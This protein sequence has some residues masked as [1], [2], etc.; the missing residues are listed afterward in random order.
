MS[1]YVSRAACRGHR[2]AQF[3]SYCG[4]QRSALIARLLKERDVARFVV[5]P[6]GYGK[7]SLVIDY[8]ETMFAWSHTIWLSAQSPCFIRDLDAG[9]IASDCFEVDAEVGLVVIDDLPSLDANRARLFSDEMDALLERGCEVMV[10]CVPSCDV[11]GGFQH[12]RIRLGARDL[13]LSDDELDE[14]RSAEE[15]MRK[16]ANLVSEAHRVPALV[17]NKDDESRQAFA[18]QVLKEELPSDLLLMVASTLVLQ[19][20]SFDDLREVTHVDKAT[21]SDLLADYPHLGFVEETDRFEAAMLDVALL[22]N[23]TKSKLDDMVLR[24]VLEDSECL[25]V[26]W[27]DILLRNGFAGRACDVMRLICPRRARASWLMEHSY[28]L[29]RQACFFPSLLLARDQREARGESKTRLS[30]FEALCL[31]ALGDETGALR[32]AKRCAFDSSAPEETKICGALII[33]H[34]GSGSLIS[35]AYEVLE[36]VAGKETEA[37]GEAESSWVQLAQAWC[38]VA[39]GPQ[40]LIALWDRFS[41]QGVSEDVL[42]VC[43]SWLFASIGAGELQSE[44]SLAASGVMLRPVERYV[45]ER[46]LSIHGDSTDYFAASAGLSLEEAHMRG[47]PYNDGPLEAEIMFVLRQVEV[48]VLAQRS[49]YDQGVRAARVKRND[50]EATRP[51]SYLSVPSSSP[52]VAQSVPILSLKMFGRFEVTIGDVPI[53]QKRFKRQNSRVLLVLLAVNQGKEVSREQLM[54]AMW[55]SATSDVGR[56]NFYTVWAQLR[57]SLSL[58]DG[59]CPYLIRH[60]YGCSLEQRYVQSDVVRLSEICRELLFGNPDV[61]RWSSLFAEIDRDF[62]SELMPSERRNHMIIQARGEYRSRLVDALVAAT[63]SIVDA[64][65]PQWGIWFAREA[66][67]HDETREDAYVA[68]MRAQIAGNQR[69]AAMMTF[70]KCRRVLNDQLGIDPS[71]EANSLYESLLGSD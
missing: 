26:K 47:V 66:I 49:Q 43:A 68:L 29:V 12:D 23:S 41:E 33:A 22:A 39:K 35:Q 57:K 45:R 38:A 46:L 55:P 3:V 34:L 31:R 44:G 4:F 8:A 18:K 28:E 71:S 25:V 7:T 48:S 27:A 19:A 50:W 69:T 21:V 32:S 64:G 17:W 58:P 51:D 62:S 54:R 40:E 60:Q 15:R 10:T 61:D 70:L 67:N 11:S 65:H 9:I 20:G 37:M 6:A 5:A 36:G 24:S 42:C 16:P 1:G 59:T 13:L 30:A 63:I 52:K 14:A 2:P 56:K 53:E